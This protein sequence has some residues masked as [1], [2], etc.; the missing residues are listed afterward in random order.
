MWLIIV[1]L[2]AGAICGYTGLI[3]RRFDRLASQLTL[4]GLVLLLILMGAMIGGNADVLA[5]I[6][7][8]GRKA[9]IIAVLAVAGSVLVT[10]SVF[11][12]RRDSEVAAAGD[13]APNGHDLT[14]VVLASVA[15]GITAGRFLIP[16]SWRPGLDTLSTGA[17]CVLLL[18]IGLDLGHN[19][20]VWA[21]LRAGGLR[22]ALVPVCVAL[23][24]LAGAALAAPLTGLRLGNALAVGAGFGWYSLSGVILARIA[25]PEMGALAFLTNVTRELLA[26]ILIAPIARRL[27]HI[28]A[29]APGG[30]TAMDTTLPIVARATGAETAIVSFVSGAVLSSLVPL[31]VP[32]LARL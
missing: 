9:A 24:S 19:Q 27:G 31:L 14:L 28:T 21:R 20:T 18:G 17:L 25:G 12:R 32:L 23:G 7:Q 6:G 30:A 29:V 15:V 5:E 2:V 22:L 3:P 8:L 26:V 16:A 1:F 13:T 4:A 10:W 11:G